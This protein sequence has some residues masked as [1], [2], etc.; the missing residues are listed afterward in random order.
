MTDEQRAGAPES[1]APPTTTAAANPQI[2]E[3][4]LEAT[5]DHEAR[6]LPV[7]DRLDAIERAAQRMEGLSGLRIT[8]IRQTEPHHWILFW[9]GK[10]EPFARMSKSAAGIIGGG[11]AV[12]WGV[13]AKPVIKT[14][15][16]SG[17][18]YAEVW[19]WCDSHLTGI[20]IADLRG[21]RFAG[22]DFTGRMEREK[23]G[24]GGG[25]YKVGFDAGLQ[26]LMDA[27]LTSLWVKCVM[28]Q[29]GIIAPSIRQL[30]RVWGIQE[31]EV[32]LRGRRGH[33][34]SKET[35]LKAA[36]AYY[37]A[38]S[39]PAAPE[40]QPASETPTA[41]APAT[42][43]ATQAPTAAPAAPAPAPPPPNAASGPPITEKQRKL[44]WARAFQRAKVPEVGT[45]GPE[46]INA[47]CAFFGFP[48]LTTFPMSGMDDLLSYVD[49]FNDP[50]VP[51]EEL[52]V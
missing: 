3:E 51:Q 19:G 26:D 47:A 2:I 5:R 8:A 13:Q 33:G 1:Q 41:A 25:K 35:E 9:D 30:A 43:V 20:R 31:R 18:K 49:N 32:L 15:T 42:P 36:L 6:Q 37:G 46:I 11:F 22:E 34:L 10:G 21:K 52:P 44:V 50:A 45:V 17:K 38:Q 23:T 24:S 4:I 14:D 29:S 16:E 12:E 40:H 48:D 28:H 7:L 27:A 39:Q